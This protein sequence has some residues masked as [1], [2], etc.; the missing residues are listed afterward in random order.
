[1]LVVLFA[2]AMSA[3]A[4]A[5]GGGGSPTSHPHPPKAGGSFGVRLV[6]APKD[7]QDDPRAL[8]YIVDHV[9]PGTTFTRRFV[10]GTTSKVPLTV[11]SYPAAAAIQD[12]TWEPA[13]GR[14]PNDLS[15]WITVDRGHFVVPPRGSTT[16]RATIRVPRKA[17][18]GERYAVIWAQVAAR[19]RKSGSNVQIVNRVG[20]RVYLDVGPGGEPPSDFK[21]Y[22]V[23]PGRT[24]DGRP[25]V[26]AKIR[27]TGER[28]LDMTGKLWLT[29]GPGGLGAG[30][31]SAEASATLAPGDSAPMTFLLDKRLPDGPWKAKLVFKSGRVEHGATATL[32]FPK[33]HGWGLPAALNEPLPMALSVAGGLAGV[34]A[35]VLLGVAVRRFRNRT[36]LSGA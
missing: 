28:A 17:V 3:P 29:E 15:S 19:G 20:I 27:N 32:T 6:E 16:L 14:T 26:R 21:I 33:K 8:I 12:G 2:G 35:L 22:D 18:R 25:E 23:R 13:P 7:R 9:K 24:K 11:S 30:P 31:F 4:F 36:D 5:D 10:V 1:M 34:G